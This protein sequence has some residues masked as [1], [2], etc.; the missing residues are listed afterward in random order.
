MQGE[1]R[2][3]LQSP[4][5]TPELC[6][7]FP[8]LPEIAKWQNPGTIFVSFAG[9][10]HCSLPCFFLTCYNTCLMYKI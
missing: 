2:G 10:L 5:R 6:V 4:G 7:V 8:F 9:H 3:P 1:T